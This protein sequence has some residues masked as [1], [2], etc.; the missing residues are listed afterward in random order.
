M[1]RL[2]AL[3][4]ASA[5]LQDSQPWMV[6]SILVGFHAFLRTTELL[7]LTAGQVLAGQYHNEV[8]LY[9]GYTKSGKRRG[10]RELVVLDDPVTVALLKLALQHCDHT[11]PLI[12]CTPMQWRANFERYAN[13][14]GLLGFHLKPYSLRRGG[15]TAFFMV[16]GSV[17]PALERGRWQQSSTA[18][19][20]LTEGRVVAEHCLVPPDVRRHLEA[21]AAVWTC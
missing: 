8:V 15:A 5:A 2:M 7:S 1:S 9:L 13:L 19:I 12:N 20:Y 3:A 4:M 17:A 10:A 14:A 6:L 11:R 21:L 16:T 18:R